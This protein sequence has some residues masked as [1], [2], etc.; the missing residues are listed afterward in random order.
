MGMDVDFIVANEAIKELESLL[1][2]QN[3]GEREEIA[4]EIVDFV[5]FVERMKK[6]WGK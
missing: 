4:D 2:N 5:D 6:K 1:M 3:H